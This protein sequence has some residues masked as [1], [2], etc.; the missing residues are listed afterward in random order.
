MGNQA[1]SRSL[2]NLIQRTA[3]AVLMTALVFVTPH[4]DAQNAVVPQSRADIAFSFAPLVEKTAPAV[5]NVYA[6]K[7]V[8]ARSPAQ[9]LD[10]SAFWRLFRD[11]LLFGYGRDRI[12]N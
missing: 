5:V 11:T 8:R 3:V 7:I 12:E 2:R 9:L 10:G 1:R 4:A 6:Q